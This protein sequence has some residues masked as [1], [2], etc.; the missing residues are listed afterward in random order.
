MAEM[1]NL[2]EWRLFNPIWDPI[3][4]WL[5]QALGSELI[6]TEKAAE[7]QQTRIALHQ[8]ALGL[9]RAALD[10]HDKAL[11]AIAQAGPER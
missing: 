1:N 7:L 2:F 6:T 3:G 11:S 9:A 8:E 5:Q 10:L 4:P